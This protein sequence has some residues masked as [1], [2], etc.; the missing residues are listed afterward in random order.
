MR[1]GANPSIADTGGRIP[2]QKARDQGHAAL[3]ALLLEAAR[4]YGREPW[5]EEP[6]H[7]YM[8]TPA[9]WEKVAKIARVTDFWPKIAKMATKR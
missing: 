2:Y 8:R 7:S 5:E 1:Q 6:A 9:N 4:K 3:A